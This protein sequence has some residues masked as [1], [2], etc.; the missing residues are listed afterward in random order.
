M[1]VHPLERLLLTKN[2]TDNLPGTMIVIIAIR[3][4]SNHSL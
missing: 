3:E 2:K 1:G 4:H